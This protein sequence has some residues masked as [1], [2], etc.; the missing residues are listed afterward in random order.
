MR[1]RCLILSI[2]LV[3]LGLSFST[4]AEAKKKPASFS[5][6]PTK[7]EGVWHTWQKGERLVDLSRYYK[8]PL[9]DIEEINGL[10]QGSAPIAGQQIFFPEAVKK[11]PPQVSAKFSSAIIES[12]KKVSSLPT[13]AGSSEKIEPTSANANASAQ[14]LWPV[15]GGTVSSPFGQRGSKVHE[16]IDIIAEAGRA[17][18]AVGDGVVIYA[19]SGVRGY[20]N[21]LIVRHQDNL[22]SVYAHNRVNLVTEGTAVRRGEQIAE[23]GRSGNATTDHLHFELRQA[24]VP[25][26]PLTRLEKPQ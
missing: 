13:A 7:L 17:V 12:E 2:A 5:A 15:R 3:T 24:E 26:D 4:N 9:V 10:E 14:F 25:I 21:M 6:T 22:V 20:G 18:L 19:G 23:V 16:G 11:N 1:H 8:V